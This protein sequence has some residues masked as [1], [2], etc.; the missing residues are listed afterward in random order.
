MKYTE[1]FNLIDDALV[2][3]APCK[4]NLS[5]LIGAKRDDGFHDIETVMAKVNW[6]DE[7]LFEKTDTQGIELVCK[8]DYW[9]PQGRENLVWRAYEM[10][11]AA[12]ADDEKA[13]DARC[14]KITLTK[15]IPAGSG[16]GS[17]SSDA[18]AALL[19]MDRF[20]GLQLSDRKLHEMAGSLGSDVAFFLG[21]PLAFCWG[22]G[23]KIREIEENFPFRVLLA[24]PDV[25]VSTKGVYENFT[26]DRERFEG[27][28]EKINANIEKKN[29]DLVAAMCA[30]MLE[31]CCFDLYPQ[32]AGLKGYIK[33]FGIGHVCLSGSGSTVYCLLGEVSD[34]DVKH[35]QRQLKESFRCESLVVYNNRW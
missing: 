19:G 11:I 27:L 8:G 15:N 18:A 10:V 29:I 30:N 22:K 3:L 12:I 4:I 14:V 24:L 7:L 25:S 33:S 34:E 31:D 13:A 23:E 2:V 20:F 6:C 16:L 5:L 28:A 21:R 32:L 17:A 35:Y 1:Q 26:P 9:A